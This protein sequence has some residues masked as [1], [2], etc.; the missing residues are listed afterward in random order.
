MFGSSLIYLHK[1]TIS[2]FPKEITVH[3]GIVLEGKSCGAHLSLNGGRF[4]INIGQK[5][6]VSLAPLGENFQLLNTPWNPLS[7]Y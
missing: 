2:L 7:H 6:K 4:A 1:I 3:S 5:K